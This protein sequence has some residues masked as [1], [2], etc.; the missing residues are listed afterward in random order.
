[1]SDNLVISA[2][3]LLTTLGKLGK[4]PLERAA[5]HSNESG[6]PIEQVLLTS[7]DISKQGYFDAITA[8]SKRRAFDL[9]SERIQYSRAQSISRTLAIS[10]QAIP[11]GVENGKLV[12]VIADPEDVFTLDR[13]S[14][15][16][17]M[18]VEP[19]VTFNPDITPAIEHA[20]SVTIQRIDA[21]TPYDS[22]TLSQ[23]SSGV[24]HAAA[25][26]RIS[27]GGRLLL[28]TADD[29]KTHR[30][31]KLDG[32][33]ITRVPVKPDVNPDIM[34]KHKALQDSLDHMSQLGTF[35][36]RSLQLV[37]LA[38]KL[39]GAESTSLLLPDESESSLY[40]AQADTELETLFDCK[41]PINEESIA[42]YAYLHNN[43]L[44]V[45]QL[46][47]AP[48]HYKD[49]DNKTGFKTR[50]MLVMPLVWNERVLGVMEIV[51]KI[52]GEFTDEDLEIGRY[53]SLQAAVMVMMDKLESQ[54]RAARYQIIESFRDL[55]DFTGVE[56]R[57]LGDKIALLSHLIATELSLDDSDSDC[58]RLA[59]YVS[60]M[61]SLAYDDGY[62]L[63]A[64]M[65]RRVQAVYD[66]A[67]VV[68]YLPYDYSSSDPA[69]PQGE[70]L[71]RLSR[72]LR[73]VVDSVT[74]L[75]KQDIPDPE[76]LLKEIRSKCGKTYDPQFFEALS[77]TLADF[78]SR[79]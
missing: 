77:T 36:S 51:N 14:K 44:K 61:E 54:T 46:N 35:K 12:V 73:L 47:D 58:L 79:A 48:R 74:R 37:E 25:T 8:V 78:T 55:L 64:D 52:E 42:G 50:S 26:R 38:T 21:N 3:Q 62:S 40:F 65:L 1:M 27:L 49:V 23:V 7:G 69:Q 5:K 53:L 63:G 13:I 22:G 43:L 71:P 29:Q 17:D 9:T 57:A 75:A 34:G 67:T 66:V 39:C 15:M 18:E 30:A 10:A 56:P 11:V 76:A 72:I 28:N 2:L 33:E 45:N 68:A 4:R 19:R 41:V 6:I 60:L 16:T 70:D 59:S 32:F 24:K 20:F 31:I